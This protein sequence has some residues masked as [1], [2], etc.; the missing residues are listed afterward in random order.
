M[1]N[2]KKIQKVFLTWKCIFVKTHTTSKKIEDIL[3][4]K[5]AVIHC[6]QVWKKIHRKINSSSLSLRFLKLI[7]NSHFASTRWKSIKR[8]VAILLA[9]SNLNLQRSSSSYLFYIEKFQLIVL[10]A[11]SVKIAKTMT[12]YVNGLLA[13]TH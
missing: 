10:F 8:H 9:E 3:I 2:E 7:K 13:T 11:L 1:N 5:V 12:L 4:V 6:F